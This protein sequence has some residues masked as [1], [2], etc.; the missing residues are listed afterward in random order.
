MCSSD[1]AACFGFIRTSVQL[2]SIST[3]GMG[4]MYMV[5]L[6][7][8]LVFGSRAMS[9]YKDYF[10]RLRSGAIRRAV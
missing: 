1:L 2:D 5:N 7:L 6:P 8:M 4:F 10:R 3:I 9:A